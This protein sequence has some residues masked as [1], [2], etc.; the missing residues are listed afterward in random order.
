MVQNDNEDLRKELEKTKK[1]LNK[2]KMEQK[3]R[4]EEYLQ[5]VEEADSPSKKRIHFRSGKDALSFVF[6]CFIL[7]L[8]VMCI[9][10][11]VIVQ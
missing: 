8:I 5:D 4:E 11:G 7:V 6:G 10:I 1:E 9:I 2:L 3:I